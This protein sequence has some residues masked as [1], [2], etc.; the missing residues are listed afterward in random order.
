M[1]CCE[2]LELLESMYDGDVAVA[3]SSGDVVL[4]VDV[5]LRSDGA[6]C[7]LRLS[8]QEGGA[9][10]AS[11][12]DWRG[13]VSER[14][15]VSCAA[16]A[17]SRESES[18]LEIVD[19]ARDALNDVVV[20]EVE[21]AKGNVAKENGGEVEESWEGAL[22]EVTHFTGCRSWPSRRWTESGGVHVPKGATGEVAE[23]VDGWVRAKGSALWMPTK[24]KSSS[25]RLVHVHRPLTASQHAAEWT[26]HSE[27]LAPKAGATRKK[28]RSDRPAL[29]PALPAA[30]RAPDLGPRPAAREPEPE[31]RKPENRAAKRAAAAVARDASFFWSEND[32]EASDGDGD[33][34]PRR[35]ASDEW[36]RGAALIRAQL[37]RSERALV[38][39]RLLSDAERCLEGD[40]VY[41]PGLLATGGE[42]HGT[43]LRLAEELSAHADRGVIAWS[44]HLKHESPTFS[45]TFTRVVSYLADAFDVDVFATRLNFYRD[46]RDWKPFHRDSHA[47]CGDAKEDFTMGASFGDERDLAFRHGE[48]EAEFS[49]PQ[50]EG[51]VFAFGSATNAAFLHGVP[52]LQRGSHGGPRFSIIAWGRRRRLTPRNSSKAERDA[53]ADDEQRERTRPPPPPAAPPRAEPAPP[54]GDAVVHPDDLLALV[55]DFKARADARD[56][57]DDAKRARQLGDQ[58]RIVPRLQQVYLRDA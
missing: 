43:A 19:A 47:F 3:R 49:F 21:A 13:P 38:D 18:M 23:Y 15:R 20:F 54:D 12:E 29:A 4:S 45:P 16:K 39:A 56:A 28:P 57:A 24:G 33:A 46:G 44:K 1:D 17:A 2:E 41:A 5:K 30:R 31:P 6:S 36:N 32:V 42:R 7:A 58:A 51:D 40:C 34:A 25:V 9:Y 22:W 27:D 35:E 14:S 26:R 50:R 55:R 53:A 48:S 10:A 11:V 52:R 8:P 37:A